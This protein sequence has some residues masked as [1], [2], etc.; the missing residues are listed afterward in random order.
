MIVLFGSGAIGGE[1]L[2]Y[3][4][5]ENIECFCDNNQDLA[6]NEK[7]GKTIISFSELLWEY[8]DAV[9]II[10]ANY[11]NACAIAKQC[12]E[13][14]ILDYVFYESLKVMF[15]EGK[16]ALDYIDSPINRLQLRTEKKIA[17]LQMQVD[18]F[19]SHA[20]IKHMKPATGKLRE[21]QI[22][23][24]Q[25][26]QE[27]FD[28]ISELEIRPFIDGGNLLGYVRHNG[29]IPWDDDIDFALIR[30][31]YDRLKEYCRLHIYSNIEL[32]NGGADKIVKNIPEGMEEYYWIDFGEFIRII[33]R[34]PNERDV[35]VE[36]FVLDCYAEDYSYDELMQFS[37]T[38]RERLLNMHSLEEKIQC[39]E[40]ALSEN[41][42][43]MVKE[44]NH[45]YFGIDNM[46]IRNVH[47]RKGW[48][49]YNV[50]FPL[51]KILY[52]GEFF[53][54]PN[55]P[56]EYLQYEYDDVWNFPEDVGIP[57]HYAYLGISG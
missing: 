25:V 13:N 19:K 37:A 44:S 17:E 30:D 28:R 8:K 39:L 14:K 41:G 32:E 54:V 50:I 1:A 22:E 57:K 40:E 49:P 42:G 27:L 9:V 5:R 45:I 55:N 43:N 16:D 33:K 11:N 46:E 29:F 31:D 10:A 48:I 51:K 20:D 6:G 35:G 7:D 23:L 56:E 4:G 36:F 15:R 34:F 24:I 21:R 52:E 26:S 47:S 53:W 12:E 3:L 18:Y 38:V 2:S